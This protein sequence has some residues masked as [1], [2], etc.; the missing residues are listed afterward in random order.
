MPDGTNTRLTVPAAACGQGRA[1][2]V[3]R[4][5]QVQRV[6]ISV[7]GQVRHDLGRVAGQQ[8]D[9]ATGQVGGG[10]DLGQRDGGQRPLGGR[11]DDDRVARGDDRC[12]HRHQ[13]EQ[14][15]RAAA[16]PRR[17]RRSVPGWRTR[18]TGR[19]PD[20]RRR[21]RRRSCRSSRRSAP[22]G[23]P[24]RPPLTSPGATSRPRPRRAGRRTG[25]ADPPASRR[26]GR[27]PAHGCTPWPWTTTPNPLRAADTASRA[28]LREPWATLAANRPRLIEDL[29]RASAL[30]AR[31]CPAH[32]E[33]VGLGDRH[34]RVGRLCRRPAGDRRPRGGSLPAITP[35]P[36]RCPDRRPG[37]SGHPRG[38]SRTPGSRRTPPPGRTG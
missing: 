15:I 17:R 6:D 26:S 23:R 5:G 3:V 30:A 24:R 34:S 25:P 38:R 14:R 19:Q 4:A 33:L 28:S 8:V 22:V 12:D 37:P 31:E 36:R 2:F 1:K 20:S 29:V 7:R 21:T 27:S 11:D 16:R 32:V 18:R 13:T 35:P 9:H 10:Q